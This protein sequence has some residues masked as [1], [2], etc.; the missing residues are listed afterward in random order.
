[1][2]ISLLTN[3]DIFTGC[4]TL[5]ITL[6]NVRHSAKVSILCH[7]RKSLTNMIW[8]LVIGRTSI[9][10]YMRASRFILDVVSEPIDCASHLGARMADGTVCQI[11]IVLHHLVC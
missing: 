2:Y 8:Y 3:T 7:Q 10:V 11:E 1:M 4:G 6:G 5:S 9:R